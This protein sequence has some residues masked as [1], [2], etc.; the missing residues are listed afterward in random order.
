LPIKCLGGE[1]TCYFLLLFFQITENQNENKEK[2]I[3]KLKKDRKGGRPPKYST[4]VALAT[5]DRRSGMVEATQWPLVVVRPPPKGQE[6]IEVF[7]R[8]WVWPHPQGPRSHP[9]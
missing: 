9:H 3:K 4:E 6:K 1:P 8:K 7:F 5:P 2:L